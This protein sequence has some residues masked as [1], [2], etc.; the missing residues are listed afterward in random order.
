MRIPVARC[1]LA[2]ATALAI[3]G[4]YDDGPFN[5]LQR[6]DDEPAATTS[7]TGGDATTSGDASVGSDGGADTSASAGPFDLGIDP[8]PL[9][10]PPTIESFTISPGKL[11]Q[12]GAITFHLEASSDAVEVELVRQTSLAGDGETI[13]LVAP[14]DFPREHVIASM[15]ENGAHTYWA[16]V[17]DASGLEARASAGVTVEVPDIGKEVWSWEGEQ[18]ST[19][20]FGV[21]PLDDGAVVVGHVF[22][23]D[24]PRPRVTGINS[25]GG[26]AWEDEPVDAF[27]YASAVVVRPGEDIIVIGNRYKG[28][29]LKQ[30]M[31]MRR[32]TLDGERVDGWGDDGLT[33]ERALGI[34]L[35]DA[36]GIV[37][38][39]DYLS[40]SAIKRDLKVWAYDSAGMSRW[41]EIWARDNYNP[42]SE[43]DEQG[44]A[45]VAKPGGSMIIAGRTSTFVENEQIDT[46]YHRALVIEVSEIGFFGEMW[47]NEDD[48][49]SEL[50]AIAWIDGDVVVGG[51]AVAGPGDPPQGVVWRLQPDLE[52]ARWREAVTLATADAAVEGV[53]LTHYGEVIAAATTGG[54]LHAVRLTGDG[55]VSW[56]TALTNDGGPDKVGALALDPHGYIH[57]AGRVTIAGELFAYARKMT[58]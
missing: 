54:Q 17:R 6:G 47:I 25:A 44:Y 41:S 52:I 30:A 2:L 39:G 51:R 20:V 29:G 4:C 58:P 43:S 36:G 22:T 45:V 48:F 11:T 19:E 50:H 28:V 14:D 34:G 13:A 26:I 1:S 40:S 3:A 7:T 33:G 35:D 24:G 42:N 21:A 15:R 31:W 37:V 38:T 18:P 27:G 46:V 16:I 49:E 32:Y 9:D 10:A 57:V 56:Q 12:A 5:A 23:P 53:G 8:S 55:E